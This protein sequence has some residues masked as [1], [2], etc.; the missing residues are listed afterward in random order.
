MKEEISKKVKQ[1]IEALNAADKKLPKEVDATTN[2]EK[3]LILYP[4][5]HVEVMAPQLADLA[6]KVG[7]TLAERDLD[8]EMLDRLER[9][10][11]LQPL[12]AAA[13]EFLRRID[14]TITRDRSEA[15]FT[16]LAY[17]R[18]LTGLA[19][20]DVK[21]EA[22]LQPMVDFMSN[23]TQPKKKAENADKEAPVDKP[24]PEPTPVKVVNG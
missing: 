9:A 6:K 20:A 3:R 16:F 22:A 4:R 21:I 19:M 8:A 11:A 10:H 5:A 23:E 24:I 13:A 1:V 14:D 2:Q 12:R 18:A 17:Y 7:V 15:W